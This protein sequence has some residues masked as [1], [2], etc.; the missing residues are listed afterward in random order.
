MSKLAPR[1]GLP[2]ALYLAGLAGF[3]VAAAFLAALVVVV[4]LPPRPPGVLRT[5]Q[6]IPA[7]ATAFEQARDGKA[8]QRQP[9]LAF[10][11]AK[12]PPPTPRQHPIARRFAAQI[13]HRIGV[14]RSDV[15]VATS[16]AK[17]ETF[18]VRIDRRED[19]ADVLIHP[20][21]KEGREELERTLDQF[22][23][24]RWKRREELARSV[25]HARSVEH[26]RRMG[27][28]VEIFTMP[29]APEAPPLP[30]AGVQAPA[31]PPAP[32][33]PLFSPL[34]QGVA[35]LAGFEISARL[36]DGRWLTMKQGRNWAELGWIGRAAAVLGAALLALG[37]MAALVARRLAAPIRG[38][39]EAVQ[40]VG[41]DP[42]GAPVQMK[43]PRELRDAALAVNAMQA[44][45]RALIA[46]RTRTLAA[47]AHDMRTPLMR[48]RL[49][50]ENVE[51]EQRERLAKEVAEVEALVASFIAF[52]REDP[53]EESRVR[54][55]LVALLESLVEDHAA[56]GR[57]VTYQGPERLVVT[58]QSLGLKR[59]FANL[60]DN[61]L[62]HAERCEVRLSVDGAQAVA[63]VADNGPG[64]PEAERERIFEPFVRL[65]G[66]SS[67]G[68]GLGLAA[69]RSIA[70]AHGGEIT[71]GGDAAGAVFKVVL[72]V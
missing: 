11:I 42:G 13:A 70:R 30:P 49:A 25:D 26:A 43:G 37:L 47:V 35:L 19:R 3:A 34:P 62:K 22:G 23:D 46:D 9:R 27:G 18:V 56:A 67:G 48:L 72:P 50:A 53:A 41:V 57:A 71:A 28:S 52:A 20:R 6:L 39:A 17:T 21:S 4:L 5:D 8:I 61:A 45:L 15:L 58:G 40:A 69:A 51:P 10:R 65:R 54:L 24:L 63:E 33:I 32:P 38:F 14:E 59:L 31:P 66:A 12:T 55:D 29:G 44:R 16:F 60:I 2:I 64:V 1:G 36:P 68:A 7:F